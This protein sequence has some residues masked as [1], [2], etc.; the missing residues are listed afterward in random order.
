M[1]QRCQN[2]HNK[3]YAQYGGRGIRVCERWEKFQNFLEDMGEKP[4]G[5]MIERV[6]N[7]GNYGPEN[8]R[9]ATAKEQANNTRR[10]R[11]I[12]YSGMTLTLTGWAT[13][14]GMTPGS[15]YE[16]LQKLPISEALTKEKRKWT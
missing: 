10:N 6:D 7:N 2:P 4:P 11:W 5:K 15:L 12:S 13:R 16:R 1:R 8:C 9:W 3:K 14:I